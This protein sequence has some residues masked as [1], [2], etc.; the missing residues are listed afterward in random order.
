MSLKCGGH[1]KCSRYFIFYTS[2]HEFICLDHTRYESITFMTN[3]IATG[4]HNIGSHF[5]NKMY[6]IS[7]KAPPPEASRPEVMKSPSNLAPLSDHYWG[8]NVQNEFRYTHLNFK[9]THKIDCPLNYMTLLFFKMF[10]PSSCQDIIV[11]L[12]K[13]SN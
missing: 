12:F 1:Y 7:S 10:S 13:A 4:K 8:V 11:I 2:Y 9:K 6:F 3:N 5:L